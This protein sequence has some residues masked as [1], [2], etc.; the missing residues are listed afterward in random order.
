VHD[1]AADRADY[2]LLKQSLVSWLRH[3]NDDELRKLPDIVSKSGV[4]IERHKVW[5]GEWVYDP[6]KRTL[7]RYDNSVAAVRYDYI[8]HVKRAKAGW[9][10][11]DLDVQRWTTEGFPVPWKE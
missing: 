4:V 3:E 9:K 5:I 10:R 8:Y 6:K 2:D 1:T 11:V 7:T